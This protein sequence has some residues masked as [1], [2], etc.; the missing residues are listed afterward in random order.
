MLKQC[1]EYKIGKEVLVKAILSSEKIDG[2][3]V[4]IASGL[5]WSLYCKSFEIYDIPEEPEIKEGDLVLVK[6][7]YVDS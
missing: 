7:K 4:M 6:H 3:D 2:D 1:T 5:G